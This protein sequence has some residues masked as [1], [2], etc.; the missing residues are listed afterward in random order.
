MVDDDVRRL[1][2]TEDPLERA[3]QATDL[4]RRY[5][6]TGTELSRIR[7]EALEDLRKLGHSQ[8]AVAELLGLSRGRIGQLAT[9][10]PEPERMFLGDDDLTVLVA[11]KQ[12]AGRGRPVIAT[13]TVTAFSRLQALAGR[14]GLD[15]SM[16]A[17]PPPGLTDL[18]RDNL[19]VLGGARV[20]PLVG[21]LMQANPALSFQV[22][23]DEWYLHD[24]KSNHSYRSAGGD[25][26][27]DVA[28]LGRLSRPDNKG[29]FL[30]AAGIH[31]IGT[32]GAVALI[33]TDIAELYAETRGKRFSTLV[34]CRYDPDT[35][36]VSAAERVTP[37][38]RPGARE[39]ST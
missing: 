18:N 29:T 8:T 10:G 9:A 24:A 16:E 5:Q 1:R 23:G 2:A 34:Q 7:R 6:A 13:E 30:L 26:P 39:A 37:L 36:R 19:I 15:A 32:Q 4:L 38:Y 11:Q 3:R 27:T 28:Y 33:E 17:I 25:E 35:L 31:P 22:D 14:L 20:F 21:Q 12:E